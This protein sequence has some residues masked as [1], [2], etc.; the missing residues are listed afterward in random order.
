MRTTRVSCGM[1]LLALLCAVAGLG[2][3]PAVAG[4]MD[5]LPMVNQNG[6]STE[7][8]YLFERD[9]QKSE[10]RPAQRWTDHF[11]REKLTL[12][13]DGYSYHPRFI[14]YRF[15]VTGVGK[16]EQYDSTAVGNQ[17]WRTGTGLEYDTNLYFLPEHPYNLTLY[18]RRYEMMFKEQSADT[19]SQVE[20]TRGALFRYK[21]K[22]YF[23]HATY[24]D[25]SYDSGTVTT[26]VRRV[27][28]GAEHFKEL[29][30]G[31]SIASTVSATPAWFDNSIGLEGDSQE[32]MVANYLNLDPV[33]LSSS[34][35]WSSTQQDYTDGNH[36]E[37]SSFVW[38]EIY[39]QRLP[40]NFRNDILYRYQENENLSRERDD[41]PEVDLTDHSKTLDVGLV[42]RLYDSVNTIYRFMFGKRKSG[43]GESTSTSNAVTVNY[44]KRIP[45]GRIMLTSGLSRSETENHGHADVVDEPH[46]S[47]VPGAFTL[48]LENVDR[49]NIWVYIVSPDPPFKPVPLEEF[50]NYVVA[51]YLNTYEI[52]IANVLPFTGSGPFSFLVSYSLLSGQF[53]LGTDTVSSHL[54]VNLVDG[55]LTPYCGYLKVKTEVLSG[56]FPGIPLDSSTYTAGLAINLGPA[57]LNGQYQDVQWEASPSQS[58]RADLQYVYPVTA[59]TSLY[60]AANY[61]NRHYSEG[62]AT[63]YDAPYTEET[64]TV[65]GSLTKSFFDRSLYGT[66]GASYSHFQ[67]QVESNAVTAN[68]SLTWRIGKLDFTIGASA[69]Q[70]DSKGDEF[71]TMK[72]DHQYVYSRV[73]RKLF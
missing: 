15:S 73:S 51:P 12:Y 19:H 29:S 10:D 50:V 66:V 6:A 62:T 59:T 47:Q 20:T 57:Q 53:S 3:S 26:D 2:V 72:R 25:D 42:H 52:Q 33:Q 23:V 8:I 5:F 14:Q 54:S 63:Y 16:Q 4:W 56:F 32:Y 69:Y 64:E 28:F 1:I 58:W 21:A 35:G 13:S 48:R 9:H 55:L 67:G 68:G 38:T 27:G 65:M 45:H 22:P 30:G 17:G 71:A 7:A 31:R 11:L 61:L 60:A 24:A 34:V 41:V 46:S 40:W 39:S 49:T 36:L 18:D 70:T 37:N 44:S 43:G